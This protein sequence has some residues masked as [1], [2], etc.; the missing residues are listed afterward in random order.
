M[1]NFAT[2]PK[3]E[4]ELNEYLKNYD[5]ATTEM[6]E[7][8][9]GHMRTPVEFIF[10]GHELR[11]RDGRKLSDITSNAIKDAE[12][13][14]RVN[15]NLGFELRRR[16]IE[17]DEVQE[18]NAMAVDPNRPNTIVVVSDFPPELY[19][20]KSDVG[21]YN[22]NRKQTYLRVYARQPNGNVMMLSQ[23]LDHSN[24][25]A[26][27]QIYNYHDYSVVDGELL[28]QRI[29]QNLDNDDQIYL[30]DRLTGIY[31]R[32]MAKQYGGDWY[33]GRK[34]EF[35]R[36]TFDFVCGQQDLVEA[37]ISAQKYHDQ[38]AMYDIAAALQMRY[39]NKLVANRKV[40][41]VTNY[42]GENYQ[43][44]Q[45]V[46][47]AGYKARTEGKIFSACG[48]T[49]SPSGDSL[50]TDETLKEAG[51]DNQTNQETKYGFDKRMFCVVCQAPPKKEESKKMCGPCGICKTCDVK[52]KKS[53]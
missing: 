18:V 12:K 10:D 11:G 39:E 46:L 1:E 31:D 6:A 43:L 23:S 22:V 25:Q 15:P 4:V 21:G 7:M 42:Q 49:L 40:N 34:S 19:G 52:L 17:D 45:E 50:S 44:Q 33:A 8:L 53:S 2:Q 27:E 48:V 30:V 3:L 26:L 14:V 5:D 9:E 36:N 20:V 38:N 51:L 47:L 41:S 37:F 13:I 32:S 29:H 35:G 24:R 16:K 28:G